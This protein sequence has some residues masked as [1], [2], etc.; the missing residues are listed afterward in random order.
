[1]GVLWKHERMAAAVSHVTTISVIY[2]LGL[3]RHRFNMYDEKAR[4]AMV[5]AALDNLERIIAI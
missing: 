3:L 2:I 1:M 5:P 4:P